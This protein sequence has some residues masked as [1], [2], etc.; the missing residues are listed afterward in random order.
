MSRWG[1]SQFLDV[2]LG[3]GSTARRSKY[4][5]TGGGGG[6]APSGIG[7]DGRTTQLPAAGLPTVRSM[8]CPLNYRSA[9][10][11]VASSRGD[12]NVSITSTHPAEVFST[13]RN[14]CFVLASDVRPQGD[15]S[16]STANSRPIGLTQQAEKH[17]DVSG[18]HRELGC[19]F[20]TAAMCTMNTFE[21]S[22]SKVLWETKFWKN[23]FARA[24]I[25]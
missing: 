3:G 10:T 7:R 23:V 2:G 22:H 12:S 14:Q 1:Q 5:K 19:I 9:K 15:N 11:V 6:A 13:R 25:C 20:R 17:L 21:F 24:Q 16:I 8:L 4:P 18:S